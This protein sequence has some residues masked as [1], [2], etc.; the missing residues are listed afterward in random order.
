MEVHVVVVAAAIVGGEAHAR[1]RI[2]G[3]RAAH[4]EGRAPL[5]LRVELEV[6]FAREFIEARHLGGDVDRAAHAR[7]GSTLDA[8]R[9]LDDVDGI[10]AVE[11]D[12]GAVTVQGE[13]VAHPIEE[14]V[15][16]LAADAWHVRLAERRVRITARRQIGKPA[17]IL[18]VEGIELRLRQQG[19]VARRVHHAEVQTIGRPG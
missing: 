6:E 5:L 3:Q 11:T 8:R 9:T 4:I 12:R 18:D 17:R 2:G 14:Q 16:V 19:V 15:G 1:G 13:A 10:D 7:P